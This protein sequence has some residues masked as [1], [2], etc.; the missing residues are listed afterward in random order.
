[1]NKEVKRYSTWFKANKLS[2][3]IDK[4]KWTIFPPLYFVSTNFSELFM[5][6]ITPDRETVANFF[7]VFID[8]N[9][10]WKAHITT[11]SIK[12]SK[13][14]GVLYQARLIIPRKQLNQL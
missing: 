4:T 9:V 13:S 6:G 10:A 5:V 7:S 2:V 11:V 1:M 12:I 14:V 3:N 8:K